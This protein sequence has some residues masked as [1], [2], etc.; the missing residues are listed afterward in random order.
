MRVPRGQAPGEQAGTGAVC[1]AGSRPVGVSQPAE[2]SVDVRI[3]WLFCMRA[4]EEVS[5]LVVLWR[6]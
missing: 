5:E 2:A 1:V 6:C 4:G 3:G